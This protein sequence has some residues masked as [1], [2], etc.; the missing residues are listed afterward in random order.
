[1]KKKKALIL[2]V[3]AIAGLLIYYFAYERRPKGP[4]PVG[5]TG[6]VESLEY[7]ISSKIAGKVTT[8]CCRE[9][10]QVKAGQLVATIQNNDLEAAL[11]EAQSTLSAQQATARSSLDVV[12]NARAQVAVARANV[13]NQK[14]A[15]VL[16]KTQLDQ[17]EIDLARSR[18]LFGRGIVAQSD[19]DNAETTRNSRAATLDSAKAAL[20][21]SRS[22]VDAA[23]ASLKKA[24]GDVKTADA[25]V[26]AARDN[27]AFQEAKL[28]DSQIYAP[29]DGVVEYRSV[30]EGEVVSP[31][32]SILT[33]YDLNKLWVRIDLEQRYASRVKPGS[34]ATI[35]I[36]GVPGKVFRGV[37]FDVGRL[38]EFATERDV[39]RG[40][41][42]IK[43]FRTRMWVENK[44]GMLKPGMTVEVEIK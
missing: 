12:N 18:E 21:L 26:K 33:L 10:A 17:S 42:D 7:S 37:V 20:V 35:T 3:L 14:A 40:R 5:T 30:E 9:G 38:G 39:T 23:V 28:A 25:Q 29:A 41:Q 1:M 4:E 19:L 34:V 22:Q 44:E 16:A 13:D 36:D 43:T 8:V 11:R 32:Q 2:A 31:G 15:V 24:E 6:V 27:V